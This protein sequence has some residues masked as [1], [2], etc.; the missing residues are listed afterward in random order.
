VLFTEGSILSRRRAEPAIFPYYRPEIPMKRRSWLQSV[1]AVL[2][3][4]PWTRVRAWTQAPA[5]SEREVATLRAVAEVVLPAAIGVD[6]R[7]AAV[8]RFVAWVANYKQNADR[9]H[10]YGNS[11]LSAATGPSPA[12]RYPGQFAAF[13][14]A[15]V[16]SGAATFAALP[17]ADRRRLVE[18]ALNAAPAVTR[19]PARP[20]GA[21]LVADFMGFYFNSPEA[22]DLA[23]QRD[24]GKDRCRT[25]AGS[26]QAPPQRGSRSA[27]SSE[28]VPAASPRERRGD[29]GV[30]ASE[31][32]GGFAGA[33][34]PK[35]DDRS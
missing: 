4:R 31:R 28:R 16:E 23:Y 35:N 20:T 15:A 10:G 29:H 7:Q 3:T 2:V 32:A 24:I 14:R 5:L 11:S 6:A 9:G 26:E 17:L 18:A 19:L 34:P 25:L 27:A 8:D 12:A 13:D 21:N 30:P 22:Y 1:A 33:E